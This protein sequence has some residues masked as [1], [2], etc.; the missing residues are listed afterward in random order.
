MEGE[1]VGR[2][3]GIRMSKLKKILGNERHLRAH[4]PAEK[5]PH[6]DGLYMLSPGS[7]TIR[8]GGTVE[9]GVAPW[10]WALRASILP[11]WKPIFC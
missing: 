8:R 7:G 4:R 6:C 10:V 1:E 11:A 9:V 5:L 3:A 2:A